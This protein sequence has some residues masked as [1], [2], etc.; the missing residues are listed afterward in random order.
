MI[1]LF[2]LMLFKWKKNF[3]VCCW[4]H[5]KNSVE[6]L[7]SLHTPHFMYRT[8]VGTSNM[9]ISCSQPTFQIITDGQLNVGLMLASVTAYW[10][11][12]C[13]ALTFTVVKLQGPNTHWQM[14]EPKELLGSLLVILQH[15]LQAKHR[16]QSWVQKNKP[17]EGKIGRVS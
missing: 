6:Q 2:L 3:D 10:N 12:E 13:D 1:E 17:R 14:D 5:L 16:C 15:R 4:H 7:Q 11:C 8:H 9:T